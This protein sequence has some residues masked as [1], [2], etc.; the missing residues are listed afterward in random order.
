MDILTTSGSG[1][2][3]V[4][5]HVDK[6][7]IFDMDHKCILHEQTATFYV[8]GVKGWGI[9]E[10]AFGAKYRPR[11]IQLIDDSLMS[12]RDDLIFDLT[13]PGIPK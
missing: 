4:E 6:R 3:E 2:V 7:F 11:R 10:C 5:A 1:W 8:G 9:V 13:R 12:N